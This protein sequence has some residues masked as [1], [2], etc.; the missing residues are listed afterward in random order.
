MKKTNIGR[1]IEKLFLKIKIYLDFFTVISVLG[2]L[3][4]RIDALR[5]ICRKISL[6]IS[7]WYLDVSL[8]CIK[9]I[10]LN[11]ERIF[12]INYCNIFGDGNFAMDVGRN[13][14]LVV[15]KSER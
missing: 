15:E 1:S 2:I 6:Y 7:T 10:Y 8:E 13:M 3:L 11:I 9:N 14:G 5:K 4:Y 12:K